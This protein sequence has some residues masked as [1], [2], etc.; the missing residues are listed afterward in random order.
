MATLTS[1]RADFFVPYFQPY[2]FEALLFSD[3]NAL[4]SV[5]ET[6][7]AS[8]TSLQAIRDAAETPEYINDAPETKPSALLERYLQ[9]PKYRKRTHGPTIAG[10][11]GLASMEDQCKHFAGWLEQLRHFAP[12][13]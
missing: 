12:P 7:A 9:T 6:W 3:V 13:T 11:I 8:A 1:C 4:V 10:H 5:E 2:E